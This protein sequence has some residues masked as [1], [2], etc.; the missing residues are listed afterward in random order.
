MLAHKS[1]VVLLTLKLFIY[2]LIVTWLPVMA[3]KDKRARH[4]YGLLDKVWLLDHANNN[5]G[6]S[7]EALKSIGVKQQ[8]TLA[9]LWGQ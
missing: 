3:P 4:D 6:L 9:E 8:K 7:A 1:Y 5:R 2:D